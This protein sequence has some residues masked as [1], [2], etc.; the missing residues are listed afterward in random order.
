M[1]KTELSTIASLNKGV[2]MDY[3]IYFK[4]YKTNLSLLALKNIERQQLMRDILESKEPSVKAQVITDMPLGDHSNESSVE[5]FA[6]RS[7]E[8]LEE[9]N[10]RLHIVENDVFDLRCVCDEAE[11]YLGVLGS[12]ERYIIEQRYI[13]QLKWPLVADAYQYRYK[14]RLEERRLINIHNIALGKINELLK[15]K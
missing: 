12:E 4:Q 1:T 10:A 6:V 3:K 14:K 5:K 9:L 7:E 8:R 11:A 13:E 15:L 2:L